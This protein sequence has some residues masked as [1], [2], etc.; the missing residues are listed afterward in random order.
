[1]LYQTYLLAEGDSVSYS[2]AY[3]EGEVNHLKLIIIEHLVFI[4]ENI[5]NK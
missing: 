1:M 2:A 3:T 4:N 5:N